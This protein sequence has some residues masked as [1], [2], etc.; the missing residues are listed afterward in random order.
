V[1]VLGI[2]LAPLPPLVVI[3]ESHHNG[4]FARSLWNS[5]DSVLTVRGLVEAVILL[6]LLVSAVLVLIGLGMDTFADRL[7]G[8]LMLVGWLI[9]AGAGAVA[10]CLIG[11]DLVGGL[12]L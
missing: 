6:G 12:Q 11:A 1:A 5:V 3:F 10:V 2:G 7:I 8:V 9:V 4:G